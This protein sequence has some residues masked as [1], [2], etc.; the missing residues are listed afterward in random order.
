MTSCTLES[1]HSLLSPLDESA[2]YLECDG[3]SRVAALYL[4]NN[5]IEYNAYFGKIC[6]KGNLIPFHMWLEVGE[7]II[8]YRLRMWLPKDLSGVPHGVFKKIDHPNLYKGTLHHI[9]PDP[10]IAS[11][12]MSDFSQELELLK[13]LS[14]RN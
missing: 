10:F 14:A 5:G 11:I 13:K 6:F 7:F 4:Y 9:E 8:D 3:F 2:P 12:L 1:L